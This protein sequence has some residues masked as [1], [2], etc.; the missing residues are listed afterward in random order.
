MS[1]TQ[2]PRFPIAIE[3]LAR[4][5]SEDN[6]RLRSLAPL[7]LR[8]RNIQKRQSFSVPTNKAVD[9]D[10]PHIV[11]DVA[12]TA[13]GCVCDDIDVVV[14]GSRIIEAR[15]ACTLGQAWFLEPREQS[16][17]SCLIEGQPAELA[18]GIERAAR[19][20]ADARY[21][22]IYGLR[23][24]SS[25]AQQAAADLADWLGAVI[26]TP[27]SSHHGPWGVS[28]QGVG[29]VT[30]S[31]GEVA[32]RG[33]LI[34]FWGIDP[35]TTHPRHFER[36]S[37][38]PKGMF[39]PRGRAD[40]TVIVVDVER[41]ASAEAADVFIQ[42]EPDRDFEALWTLRALAADRQLD[43]AHVC[44]STGVPL[45]AWQDLAARMKR[46]KF[47]VM[48]FGPGLA[49][50]HGKHL[51]TE[52]MLALI[53]DM[54]A[55]TRFV[56]KSMRGS[57]NVTG[58][59]NV[60]A[61]R[62]GFAFAVNLSRGYPRFNP[63]EYSADDVLAR[64]EV[65]AAL[66]VQCDVSEDFG[67]AAHRHLASIPRIVLDSRPTAETR[68]ASV[69]F[70]TATAGIHTGGTVYRMDEIPLPLRQTLTS[71]LPTDVEILHRVGLRVRELQQTTAS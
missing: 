4:S 19:I 57:G 42:V 41:T 31:L 46:A 51:N 53:R 23:G 28:F 39:V 44:Q 37:L 9:S 55:Y 63:G 49:M 5:A 52:A 70:L 61:W 54:N 26:D 32:N 56:G 40:R 29:E 60:L 27:T 25:E 20:L 24:T 3:A 17:P 15:R 67:S 34:I 71:S 65:D 66:I 58:A 33:D 62:T 50:T 18:A 7:A 8:T 2:V 45:A 13:C 14:D 64:G 36:Y 48:F 68:G 43:D 6:G 38:F 22:L 16:L 69:E 11:A 21:P 12:C 10:P 35:A 30:S 47:G 1:Q 59:D